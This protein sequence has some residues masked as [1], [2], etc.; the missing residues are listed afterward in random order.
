VVKPLVS[1]AG[2]SHP[3]GGDVIA[4]IVTPDFHAGTVLASQERL[5]MTLLFLLAID[6]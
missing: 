1:F 4:A 2:A 3:D 6:Q 5:T